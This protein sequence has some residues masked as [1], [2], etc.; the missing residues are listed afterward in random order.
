MNMRS[1]AA[2]RCVRRPRGGGGVGGRAR[3]ARGVGGCETSSG[4]RACVEGCQSVY[5][6]ITFRRNFIVKIISWRQ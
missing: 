2:R 5:P 4:K 1:A 6:S 3:K